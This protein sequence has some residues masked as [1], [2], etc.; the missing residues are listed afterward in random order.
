[1]KKRIENNFFIRGLY[2]YWRE[3]SQYF[4][5]RRVF[6]QFSDD[7]KITPPYMWV[8]ER[9]SISVNVLALAPM[10]TYQQSMQ[11]LF[12]EATVQ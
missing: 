1:M 9:T 12:V 6:G 5:R 10:H 7:V 3:F 8:I 2:F 11:S 4:V